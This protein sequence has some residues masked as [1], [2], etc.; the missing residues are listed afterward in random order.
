MYTDFI[1]QA[2]ADNYEFVTLE[3]LASRV[4]AQQK[5]AIN[6]TTS[7]NAISVTITPDPSAPDLGAMALD[8]VNGGTEVIENVTNWYAYNAQEL[9]LPRNGG[10]FTVNLG[11][12]Q[13]DVTHID[14]LPMRADLLSVSGDGLDLSFSLVGDGQVDIALGPYGNIT[15]IVTG[16]TVVSLSGGQLDLSLSGL[17][18]HDVSIWVLPSVTAVSFSADSGASATDL[19]T[20][21]ATQTIS[22][23]LNTALPIGDVVQLSLDNGATWLNATAAAG[24]TSF[25]LAGVA[26]T[27]SNTL[28]ARVESSTGVTGP[29][30]SKAYVLDQTPPASPSTPVMTAASDSG[31]SHSDDITNVVTPT[32]AGTAE[33]GSTVTLLDGTTVIGTGTATNGTW[34]I[35]ASTLAAGTHGIKAEATDAAGNIS[36]LSAALAVV[37]DTSAAAPTAL[38]LTP[39]SDSGLSNTDD[40]T[41]VTKP[42]FI[43]GGEA[44]ATVTLYDGTT[45]I[46]A[47]VVAAA[48]TFSIAST[49]T[50]ANGKHGITAKEVDL[51]GN[52][53]VASAVL[54]VTIDTVSPAAPTNLALAAASDSGVSNGDDITNVTTPTITG[55]AEA[56]SQVK[57]YDGST[58]IATTTTASTGIWSV[59]SSKLADGVHAVTATAT[60]AA[61]NVGGSSAKLWVTIDT[62]APSAPVFTALNASSLL[63]IISGTAEAGSMV[64]L[65]NGTTSLGM[66]NASSSGTWNW[67]FLGTSSSVRVLTASASDRAGNTSGTSGTVQ[68]GTSHADQFTA[69]AGNDLMYGG[70]GADTFTFAE[71]SGH[72]IIQDFAASGLSHDVIDFHGISALSSFTSIMGHAT[73]VGSGTVIALDSNNS[74]TLA[75]ATRSALTASDFTFV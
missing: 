33:A 5:A 4:E 18:E 58:V 3:D 35:T 36:A 9:F 57:L 24:G 64:S 51:A 1:A 66:T 48:G 42:T 30:F 70:G 37:I 59:A 38:A 10:T 52:V 19:I 16:A 6:Y 65:F 47:G 2:A 74:L 69:T 40:I 62:V 49:P 72:D 13:D 29:L 75:N 34:S 50:L 68:L 27:G 31:S 55:K 67:L 53:S 20:N 8:V 60:D 28:E 44:G 15:P 45:V 71:L 11:T 43:G 61:G 54:S 63:T 17:T 14:S 41:N 12:T 39:A 22:G 56:G 25:T 32:F 21:V 73:Q 7:G 26:L 46:G 23:T